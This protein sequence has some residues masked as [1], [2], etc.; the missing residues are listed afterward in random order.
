LYLLYLRYAYLFLSTRFARV[1][2]CHAPDQLDVRVIASRYVEAR[3]AL[4]ARPL[5]LFTVQRLCQINSQRHLAHVGLAYKKVGM[6][7]ALALQAAP[8]QL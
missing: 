6:R 3:S 1:S 2:I 8:Q 4:A 7:E 5:H